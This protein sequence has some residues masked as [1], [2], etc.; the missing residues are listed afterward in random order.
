MSKEAVLKLTKYQN[1][2]KSRLES[3]DLPAKH[4]NREASYRQFLAREL[5]SVTKKVDFLKVNGS[6]KK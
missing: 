2:L 6:D 5:D 1:D 3:K 4:K